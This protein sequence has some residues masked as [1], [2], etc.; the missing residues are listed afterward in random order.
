[1]GDGRNYDEAYFEIKYLRA[2]T[3][4][5]VAP[6]PSPATK[7]AAWQNGSLVTGLPTN[8]NAAVRN[9]YVT[10]LGSGW[11][12]LWVAAATLVAGGMLVGGALVSDM[13]TGDVTGV[14]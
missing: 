4:G 7:G 1:V 9:A 5:G 10:S 8:T 3:T 2:Y 13:G 11:A 12:G 14:W 6:T